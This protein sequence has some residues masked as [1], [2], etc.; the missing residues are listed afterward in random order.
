MIKIL[1]VEDDDDI[2]F[3]N[4]MMLERRGYE[5]QIAA[6]LAEVREAVF[7]FS[8]GLILLDIMLPDGSGI[9][10]LKEIRKSYNTPVLLLTSLGTSK[11]IVSGLAAG[12]NDYISKPFDN[13]VLLARIETQLRNFATVPDIITKGRLSLDITS[14]IARLDGADLILAKKNLPC[15]L[16]LSKM[17]NG[18]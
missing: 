7:S 13:E 10:F 14:Q 6:T 3:A 11:D 1:M 5:V 9:D 8:P 4:Q 2:S 16:S 17:K 18:I 15:C 12:G